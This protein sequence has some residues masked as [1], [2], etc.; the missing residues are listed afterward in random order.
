MPTVLTMLGW[1]FFFYANKNNEPLHIH[2]QKGGAEAKYWLDVE[3]FDALEAYAYQMSPTDKRTVRRIIFDHFDYI[4]E[5][6][7]EFEVRKNG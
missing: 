7:N 6:W 1:R 4:V 5:Q 2:C 3:Q